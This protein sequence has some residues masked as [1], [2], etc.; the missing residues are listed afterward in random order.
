MFATLSHKG[1]G[2][3]S[4]LHFSYFISMPSLTSR[5]DIYARLHIGSKIGT[6]VSSTRAKPGRLD[7]VAFTI[8]VTTPASSPY[9]QGNATHTH[10]R[11]MDLCRLGPGYQAG[12]VL[13]GRKADPRQCRGVH[14]RPVEPAYQSGPD[15]SEER[16]TLMVLNPCSASLEGDMGFPVP[17]R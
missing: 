12:A 8:E 10:W 16:I 14:V 7:E 4:D 6:I 13:S 9:R 5:L 3:F 1:R 2:D 17:N 15:S 11:S